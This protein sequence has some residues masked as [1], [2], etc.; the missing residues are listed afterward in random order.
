M[1]KMKY[2]L[3]NIGLFTLSSFSVKILSFLTVPLYTS[4]LT[5]EQF[6]N[7]D[8]MILISQ[9]IT[10]ILSLSIYDAI[11]RFAMDKNY[12]CKYIFTVGCLIVISS[13]AIMGVCIPVFRKVSFIEGNEFYLIG[14]YFSGVLSTSISYF[15]RAIDRVKIIVVNS[16]LSTSANIFLCIV[17]IKYSLMKEEGY[18]L[19]LILANLIGTIYMVING[20]LWNYVTFRRMDIKILIKMLK[21]SLPLMPNSICWWINSSINRFIL[22]ANVSKN[23]VGLYS[24][25]NK[26]P[27]MLS[28][29]TS[30]FQQAWTLSSINEYEQQKEN[31]NGANFYQ[32]VFE[33]Y[34]C[35]LLFCSC[36]LII[37]AS[38]IASILL[39]GE[40]VNGW[41]YIP[42]LI[43][44]FYFN[45]LNAFIGSILTAIKKTNTIFWS[46][47][48]GALCNIGIGFFLI[49]VYGGQGAGVS[50]AIGYFI[51]WIF[52]LK[53]VKKYIDFS[54]NY[55]RV[56]IDYVLLIMLSIVTL[57][58]E[59]Y[60][61]IIE[62]VII[63]LIFINHKK[64]IIWSSGI[65]KNMW[66][67]R[68]SIK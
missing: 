63:F 9:L 39:K 20:K 25:S 64:E 56:S 18:Y 28:I 36:F 14:I 58:I 7:I 61:Y 55:M 37:T 31:S 10:P 8:L 17:F 35:L 68:N 38:F 40:F 65:L 49:K 12:D 21:Y 24:A 26:I 4:I 66:L 13:S 51:M 47:L 27:N 62:G 34:N 54:V 42:V 19:A 45:S 29:V 50:I 6:A 30:T 44:G 33:I 32:S 41:I 59:V 22:N 3:K 53:L 2:L 11:I 60:R 67:L 16:I 15:L 5:T 23:E 57:R 46:T 52:R 43:I 1:N 48:L